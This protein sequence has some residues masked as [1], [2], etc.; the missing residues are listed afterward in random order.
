MGR[1]TE[2]VDRDA[3]LTQPVRATDICARA[4]DLI[5]GDR[6]STHGNKTENH[7]NIARLWNAYLGWRLVEGGLLTP[8]DVALMMNQLKVARTMCGDHNPD[9][10]IDMAGSSGR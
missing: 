6:E 10:Y 8:K 4:A 7:K 1:D 3:G 2:G 9:D 5:G